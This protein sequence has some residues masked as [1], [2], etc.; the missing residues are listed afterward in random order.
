MVQ[1]GQSKL[2]NISIMKILIKE[3]RVISFI[4]ILSISNLDA[5]QNSDKA[6]VVPFGTSINPSTQIKESQKLAKSL[7]SSKSSQWQAKGDQ[8]RFYHFTEANADMPY[9]VYVPKSWDGKSKLPLVLFLHGAW[10]DE[11]SYLDA[12]DGQMLKLAD[13]YGFLLVSPLGYSKLGGY[14]TCLLLPA[15]FG[16]REAA[17]KI[18]AQ[19][20]AERWN[21][22][23]LSEKD[24]INVLEIVLNEYPIDR[25]SMFLTGH[26]MGSGGTWYLGAK[27]SVYWK[28]LAPMSGPFVE[29]NLYPWEQIRK[30]PV[31]ISEGLQSLASLESSR[32]MADWMKHNGFTVEYK[33][34]DAD[35]PG[36][37][38]LVLPDVFAFFDRCRSLDLTS[39]K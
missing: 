37:V 11:S 22:L 6:R 1:P 27:Y 10:N 23:A 16:K 26:S 19:Q 21:T 3:L 4:L 28:A 7:S 18:M 12:N 39:K 25:K 33:E 15:V 36:M 20:T 35:H 17:A 32:N 5:Q 31:F 30:M 13:K 34:V 24:V 9:R 8:K 29:E 14:G 2:L 38:P